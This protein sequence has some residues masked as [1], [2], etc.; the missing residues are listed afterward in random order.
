MAMCSE[1]GPEGDH[2]MQDYVEEAGNTSLCPVTA[3]YKGCSEK[4]VK[5]IEKMSTK[6]ADEVTAQVARLTKMKGD[7]MTP[8]LAKWLNQRLNIL[9]K[10]AAG[11][12]KDEL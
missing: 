10:F 1:L 5:F 12:G 4:E 9:Q 8:D 11:G 7:K 3:P 2:Y 6:S